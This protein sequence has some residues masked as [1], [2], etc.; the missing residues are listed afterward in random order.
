MNMENMSNQDKL[1][2]I[3]QSDSKELTPFEKR[4]SFEG[5]TFTPPDFKPTM[6]QAEVLR[7]LGFERDSEE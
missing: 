6:K 4:M 3:H 1:K 5:G 2:K 7:E